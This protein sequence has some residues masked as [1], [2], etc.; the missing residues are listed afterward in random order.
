MVE[1]V[2]KLEEVVHQI[3]EADNKIYN[4]QREDRL[5]N[6]MWEEDFPPLQVHR[7]HLGTRKNGTEAYAWDIKLEEVQCKPFTS[8]SRVMR[9]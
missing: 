4:A 2:E 8:H 9:A 6:K 3:M 1:N 5:R 7:R